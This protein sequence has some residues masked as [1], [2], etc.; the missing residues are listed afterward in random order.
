MPLFRFT[1]NVKSKHRVAQLEGREHLVVPMVMMTEGV[2]NGT[3][4]PI[5]YEAQ[6]LTEAAPS[7]NHKPI[8]IDHPTLGVSGCTPEI[9]NK[10]KVG[11]VLN[12]I[13]NGKQRAEAWLDKQRLEALA[14]DVLKNVLN[15]QVMEVSTGLYVD[16][17]AEIGVWNEEPYEAKAK[18]H[19]PDHL[20]I[21]TNAVG[22]CSNLDG[23]GLLV[24]NKAATPKVL[25][26][27]KE[28]RKQLLNE[29]SHDSIRSQLFK[30]LRER[31][32]PKMV[33]W[34]DGWLEDV[35]DTFCIY[36]ENAKL[37]KLGYTELDNKITLSEDSPTEVKRVTEYRTVE[38]SFVGNSTKTLTEE[39]TMDKKAKV[40]ALIANKAT[41][42][43]E[44]DR[45]VL[46]AL[47]EKIIDNMAPIETKEEPVVENKGTTPTS[48][49]TATQAPVVPVQ[50]TNQ[51][52]PAPLTN[53]AWLAAAPPG[54]RSVVQNA[55]AVEAQQKEILVKAIT[56]N[57]GNRFT[58]DWLKTQDVPYLQ[59]LVALAT[60]GQT[61]QQY[62]QS[63]PMYLG[64]S[65]PMPTANSASTE[66][67]LPLPVMN[68]EVAK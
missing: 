37:W 15:E 66:E 61:E 43:E 59:S 56:E 8:L 23:A 68:F 24:D 64:A 49:T 42:W 9:I 27:Q 40:E 36:S 17:V 28:L 5:L 48:P 67:P 19:K 14:A 51:Q 12:T 33:D 31:F 34:W 60:A 54:I 21:L 46:M 62:Q 30:L 39:T 65:V 22:A 4:G 25:E 13:Y 44:K 52:A 55:M 6:D 1:H 45:E 32:M 26:L 2:H 18:N 47:D 50:T 63:P 10:Q 53:E 41:K 20:A 7:W 29:M 3:S 11:V 57:K 35:Y 38:G 16:K 58:P